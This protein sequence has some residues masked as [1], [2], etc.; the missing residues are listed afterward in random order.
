MHTLTEVLAI[1]VAMLIFAVSWHAHD[2]RHP[3]NLLILACGF[4]VVAM[5]DAAHMLTHPGMPGLATAADM[6]KSLNF[7]LAA[8]YVASIGLL[9]A[10]FFPW[11][12]LRA[13]HTRHWL[14]AASFVLAALLCWLVLWL[15]PSWARIYIAGQGPT[16]FKI[17][18]E[19][20]VIAI[21]LIAA[22]LYYRQASRPQPYDAAGLCA[23]AVVI[24]LSEICFTQNANGHDAFLLPGHIYKILACYF[25]YRA[26]F[27]SSVL[28]PY[29]RLHAALIESKSAEHMVE[30]L[31]YHDPLTKLPNRLLLKD[32]VERAIARANRSKTKAVLLCIDLDRFKT[33]NDS[34]GHA[35]GDALLK[36]VAARLG[37]C[38]R[39]TDTIS[40]LG[41]DEFVIV[42]Q[43]VST[44][45]AIVLP[46]N[47]MMEMTQQAFDA[48]G[49]QV[50]TSL[51]VGI[52]IYPDDGSDFNTLMTK[53][54]MA[55]YRAK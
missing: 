4:L 51:S 30:F 5:L 7:R 19:Y 53:A 12:P 32:R 54:D 10:A 34:L 41:G 15:P 42:L 1:A 31:A 3:G 11:Q 22:F 36:S 2:D 9:A 33:V 37:D 43:D 39:S 23:A 45:D 55:M 38:I 16:V 47:R 46:V 26:V 24:A 48:E 8:R 28:E 13:R 20:G 49:Q 50:A 44:T 14:L 52:A 21:T 6:E 18:A 17:A 25:I 27:I 40:R 29:K 35:G